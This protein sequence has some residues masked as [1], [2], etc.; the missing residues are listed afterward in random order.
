MTFCGKK[1][2]CI[3]Q[4]RRRSRGLES[5]SDTEHEK[6]RKPGIRIQEPES[7]TG[8]RIQEKPVVLVEEKEALVLSTNVE[9]RHESAPVEGEVRERPFF[10]V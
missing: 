8:V 9:E 7:E 3:C 10:L 1:P 4:E 5:G 2:F 6:P